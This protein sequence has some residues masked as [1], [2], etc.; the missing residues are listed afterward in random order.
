M[1][2]IIV[3][4]I[5]EIAFFKSFSQKYNT[6]ILTD[7]IF[8]RV[9]IVNQLDSIF[10]V[11]NVINYNKNSIFLNTKS[12][13]ATGCT[14]D[15]FFYITNLDLHDGLEC[16]I[17]VHKLKYLDTLTYK[18]KVNCSQFEFEFSY[19]LS[20]KNKEIQDDKIDI[21]NAKLLYSFELKSFLLSNFK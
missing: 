10:F 15:G 4:L 19:I 12:L 18:K 8:V 11:T 13:Y 17:Y 20:K 6:S 14:V 1:K 3:L 21:T 7:S 9:E 16:P 5:F 2:Y